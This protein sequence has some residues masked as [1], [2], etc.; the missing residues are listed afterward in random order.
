VAKPSAGEGQVLVKVRASSINPFDSTVLHGYAQKMMPLVLPV[1]LGGDIAGVVEAVGAGV[2]E[3]SAGDRVYGQANAVGGNTGAFGEYAVTSA[4]QVAKAPTGLSFEEA[5]AIP[6]TGV[7]AMQALMGHIKL[8][9]GQKILIQGGSGGIGTVAIQLAK[10]LGA[11]VATTV[12]AMAMDYAKTLGA[13]E[14]MDYK[15]RDFTEVIKDYDAVFDLVG[16]EV[17]EKSFEVVKKGGVLVSM[18][19]P[20]DEA[21]LVPTV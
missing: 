20:V 8:A 7:S 17:F 14:V 15:A 12:P 13:D 4:G 18:V 3:F 11:Y 19:A 21:K 10:H 16:G 5:A 9:A 6:L 1:T 2:S